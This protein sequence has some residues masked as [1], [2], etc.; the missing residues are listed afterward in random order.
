M[1]NSDYQ[2]WSWIGVRWSF[3]SNEWKTRYHV[4]LKFGKDWN[5]DG[6][7]LE[8]REWAQEFEPVARCKD[9]AHF[10]RDEP[11]CCEFFDSFMTDDHGYC[12]WG[13]RKDDE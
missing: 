3:A 1:T 13:V 11:Q 5:P 6:V 10:S 8:Y 9:C 2:E 4:G 7:R 12:A